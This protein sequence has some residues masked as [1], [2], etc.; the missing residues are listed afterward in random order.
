MTVTI[1][2]PDKPLNNALMK[3][4][5]LNKLC[6][7]FLFPLFATSGF[8]V[9][10]ED[11]KLQVFILAGQ[12]NMVGHANAHT[13][14]T[15]YDSDEAG[16]KK[17]TQ[18]V[19]KKGSDQI[20]K[21][22]A[23]QLALGVKIDELTG[24][25]SKDKIKKMSDGP[26]KAALEAKVEKHKEA[27]EAYRKQVVSACVVSEKVYISSIADRNKRSGPLSVG[28]G[29]NQEKI[30]PEFGFGL[31]MAQKMD[32]PILLIKTS[33]GGKSI[34]YNFRPPSSGPYE[35]NEKE[36]AGD[37]AEEIKKN[38]SLNWRMM[39]E[40]V[41]AV[42]KDL[43]KY[44]PAYDSRVGHEMAGFVWFQG[45]NDQFSDAFRDNYRQNMVH[46]IKD[47]R[48]EYKMPKMPFVI[49]VLGTN[50]TKEGVDKN[51]VSVGQR[52]AA[53][54]PDFKG[55]VVSVESYK[56]YDLKA[57]KVFDGGWAKSFAQWR[58]VGS[59]RPYHYLG[60][61]KF[62]VRLG[63]AFANA[64]F[65]LIE[66]KMASVPS[67]I[68]VASGE[69]IA[70]LGDS[71]TAAGKR[72]GGYCQ[73]VL[74]ALKDQGIETTPV[75][76]G[77][78][79][80]KSNQMLARLEKDVLRHKPDWMTL[81]CGVNDVWH[82][83]RGV[84][85]PSYKKNI[86]AIVDQAQA[87]GVK[88]MLLTSTM[89]REDQSNDLNQK[90]APYNEFIRALAKEKKCLLA[91]LNGDMQAGLKKFPA[92]APK[93]KQLTSDGVHMNKA[94]NIMMARGVAKAF[95]LTDKQLDSSAKSWK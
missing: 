51:A 78:G 45:F 75:F 90:L 57:R 13:V 32:N 50:M 8:A 92:D 84:D 68:A 18:M 80:H 9:K 17:L 24:G 72:P 10:A 76:A 86:T 14:A 29:G 65:G 33:W 59:D 21:A 58:L 35:L 46:F 6:L 93:G 49:G 64:M 91:D 47:I 11:K 37:K 94:G 66:N 88:V 23:E 55:N 26:E 73:L 25:I 44:H 52:Q 1:P 60:S 40:A 70:F 87:A 30:G 61:G 54:A 22:L 38:T 3:N 43:K 48:K 67:S 69:K 16:D 12:S 31:S 20:K 63:D 89:I 53:K 27:Y 36:K 28:Y 15:L 2:C 82:G 7:A 85:L 4:A 39:N 79:G 62:F 83:K 41:H 81:S 77:I 42:L 74:S 71:I 5:I 34:N 19:F 95:G 56:A